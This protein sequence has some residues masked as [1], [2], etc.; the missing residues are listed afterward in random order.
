MKYLAKTRDTGA[1]QKNKFYKIR[2]KKI[3]ENNKLRIFEGLKN[4]SSY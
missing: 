4:K 1:S 2:K 3:I